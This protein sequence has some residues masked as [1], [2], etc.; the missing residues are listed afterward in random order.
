MEIKNNPLLYLII[1]GFTFTTFLDA[2]EA[3]SSSSSSDQQQNASSSWLP[4]WAWGRTTSNSNTPSDYFG[5]VAS[6]GKLATGLACSSVLISQGFITGSKSIGTSF[7]EATRDMHLNAHVKFEPQNL[8]DLKRI[9]ENL[10]DTAFHL[11]HISAKASIHDTTLNAIDKTVQDIT[12]ALDRSLEKTDDIAYRIANPEIR[13]SPNTTTQLGIV[14][15]AATTGYFA[16]STLQKIAFKYI[17]RTT[18]THSTT[19]VYIASGCSLVLGASILGVLY[20]G[21]LAGNTP[22]VTQKRMRQQQQHAEIFELDDTAPS[23]NQSNYQQIV[24]PKRLT[25]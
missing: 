8:T 19:D 3:S 10:T 6:S 12:Q 23:S 17:D 22:Q 1:L 21:K 7:K 16:I 14:G 13:I 24:L 11:T 4:S 25:N 15:L 2:A 5:F 18:Q 9:S 20:S